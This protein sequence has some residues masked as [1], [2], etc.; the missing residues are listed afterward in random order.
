VR[1]IVWSE[2]T[3]GA[4][5][6]AAYGS[7]ADLDNGDVLLA[8]M[9]KSSGSGVDIVYTFSAICSC[10]IF[11]SPLYTKMNS[12]ISAFESWIDPNATRFHKISVNPSSLSY[13]MLPALFDSTKVA[14]EGRIEVSAG[15][16]VIVK[17]DLNNY[18][19]VNLVSADGSSSGT[20]RI[21]Y[22]V[23]Q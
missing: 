1:S 2:I 16:Y 7:S 14:S 13:A 15:E 23:Q 19:L 22:T 5:N 20:A 18:I 3:L 6:N 10:P 17:T 21:R 11:M 12:G 9:A 8:A 4:H